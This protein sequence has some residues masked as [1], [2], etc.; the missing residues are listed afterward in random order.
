MSLV[1]FGVIGAAKFAS[2]HPLCETSVSLSP[3]REASRL[4]KVDLYHLEEGPL[5]LYQEA[6]LPRRTI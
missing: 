5:W 4:E 3:A 1:T 6:R 2:G